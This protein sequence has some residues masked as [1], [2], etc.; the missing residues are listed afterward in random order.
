MIKDAP[1]PNPNPFKTKSTFNPRNM[2]TAIE[3]YLSSLEENHLKLEVPK[4]KFNNLT[5]GEWDALY[6][7]RNDTPIV[8]NGANKGSAVVVWDR[9]EYIKEAENQLGDNKIYEEVPNDAKPLMNIIL[10]TLEN[11]C[12]RGDV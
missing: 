5:K 8:I 3:I 7:L 1:N 10:N 9:E 6:D 12:K 2:D 11:I 4:D